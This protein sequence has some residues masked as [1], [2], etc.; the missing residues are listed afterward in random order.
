MLLRVVIIG[1]G[2]HAKVIIEAVRAQGGEVVGLVAQAND[3]APV[4][5]APILGG[6]EVLPA[7]RAQS[8][9]AAI[10]AIGNNALRE[11]LGR[12]AQSLGFALPHVVHPTAFLSPSARL[13]AG[14]VVM[15]R[16][17]VGTDTS[18]ADL[19]I[20]NTA[21]AV[22]HDNSIGLAAHIAPGCA[23][24]GT[25][26]VGARALV[27]VGSALRPGIRVGADAIIGAGSTVVADVPDAAMVG[28][29]PARPLRRRD[30]L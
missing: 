27:G 8:L 28:G 22:D 4:L 26:R 1:A 6:D 20:I 17:V 13:G 3:S 24:A 18:V 5:G 10:I 12:K 23:L 15:A 25:V 29:A 11:R 19:A 21:A 30:S 9:D 16:A 7:L 2:G 14:V